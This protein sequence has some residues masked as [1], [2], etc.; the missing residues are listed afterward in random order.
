MIFVVDIIFGVELYFYLFTFDEAVRKNC[1]HRTK[2]Q[3]SKNRKFKIQK[4]KN[5]LS[6][7]VLYNNSENILLSLWSNGQNL[8]FAGYK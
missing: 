8:L 5:A 3:K 2:I 6:M 4:I 1:V 7:D